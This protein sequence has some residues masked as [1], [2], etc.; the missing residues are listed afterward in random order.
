ML[1]LNKKVAVIIKRDDP[2]CYYEGEFL[3]FEDRA[4]I[5]FVVLRRDGEECWFNLT[6][7]VLIKGMPDVKP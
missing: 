2:H 7:V 6:E 5:S 4:G 3:G 1:E